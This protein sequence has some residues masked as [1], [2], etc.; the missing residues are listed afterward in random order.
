MKHFT[1]N[2][3]LALVWAG[4]L[5]EINPG[6]LLIGFIAGYFLLFWLR[7]LLPLT[8]YFKK[9]PQVLSFLAFFAGDVI[10]SNLRVA[11]E[12]IWIRGVRRPG[13]V[14]VP[15]D[16]KTDFEIT[17]LVS[18]ITLTPGTMGVDISSDRKVLYIHTMF[19][20][21]ADEIRND[22]KRRYERRVQELFQ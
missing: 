22:I 1:Y 5:G 11:R 18:L 3:L 16:V 4:L 14:A 15:L 2:V 12:V 17:L 9:V 7:R 21:T 20:T 8:T 10:R 13:I 19:V 6:T